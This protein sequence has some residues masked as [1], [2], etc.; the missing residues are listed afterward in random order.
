MSKLT[1]VFTCNEKFFVHLTTVISSLLAN[2]KSTKYEIVVLGRN[3][4]KAQSD[5]L[6]KFVREQS[7]GE[8][9]LNLF[10]MSY[11]LDSQGLRNIVLSRYFSIDCFSR[12]YIPSII[13]LNLLGSDRVLYL[14]CDMLVLDDLGCMNEI[15]F[16]GKFFAV[17]GDFDIRDRY[18]SMLV[19]W[20]SENVN[21][22]RNHFRHIKNL[23]LD[24]MLDYFNSGMVLFNLKAIHESGVDKGFLVHSMIK[25]QYLTFPD[26]DVL[27]IE[28]KRYGGVKYLPL[29]FNM[30]Q[31]KTYFRLD[32]FYNPNNDHL[33][34]PLNDKAYR[35]GTEPVPDYLQFLQPEE[36]EIDLGYETLH[37]EKLSAAASYYQAD[38]QSELPEQVD[39]DYVNF[40]DPH[41]VTMNKEDYTKHLEQIRELAQATLASYCTLVPSELEAFIDRSKLEKVK[42]LHFIGTKPWQEK[43][44]TIPYHL[45]HKYLKQAQIPPELI[46]K[47]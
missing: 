3:F 35:T 28:G 44:F 15:D 39:A 43:N 13:D 33:Y 6:K 7:Q 45:Y 20:N 41:N 42:V 29:H 11:E 36:Q 31:F 27:N 30:P 37:A 25:R 22:Y 26:Q 34:F 19:G 17:V 9:F 16:E 1:I 32:D 14:D 23:G 38:Y 2:R 21:Y 47:D 18:L 4:T 10:E 12:L 24:S 8:C 5:W 46:P 40:K